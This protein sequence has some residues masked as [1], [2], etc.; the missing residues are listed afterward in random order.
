MRLGR[1][2]II[3]AMFL[4]AGAAGVIAWQPEGIYKYLQT[5]SLYLV[6]PLTPPIVFGILSRRVTF[7][8]AAA[9][10]FSGVALSTV[11]VADALIKDRAAAS[12][13]FPLLHHRITENFTYRGCWGTVAITLVLFAVSAFTK[14]TDPEKLG[15]TTVDWGGS[16]AA[17]EGLRDWRLQLAGLLA[18]TALAYAWLW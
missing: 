9:A 15:K 11:F 10:F 5:I 4:G 3:A 17:F 7:A 6:M 18:V 13:L 14:K 12:R 16:I 8:G 2:A 1:A